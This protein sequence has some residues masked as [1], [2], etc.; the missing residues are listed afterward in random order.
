M[1]Q[2][3]EGWRVIR[4]PFSGHVPRYFWC[5]KTFGPEREPCGDQRGTWSCT[6]EKPYYEF[7]FKNEKD[8]VLFLLKWDS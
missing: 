6:W 7:R 1:G 4:S 3:T 8:A 2:L 5:I